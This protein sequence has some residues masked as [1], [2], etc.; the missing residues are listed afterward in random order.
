[1]LRIRLAVFALAVLLFAG[2]GVL[3]ERA[4]QLEEDAEYDR[5][6]RLAER[7]F[8]EIDDRLNA[9]LSE[10]EARSF[11]Q[12]RYLYVPEGAVAAD[13][14]WIRS[15][16][17]REPEADWILG[18][19]Q[20]DADGQFRSPLRPEVDER[21]ILT[22]RWYATEGIEG[23]E[24]ALRRATRGLEKLPDFPEPRP[25]Q[26]AA[27]EPVEEAPRTRNVPRSEARKNAPEPRRERTVQDTED[28]GREPLRE[29]DD[30]SASL[31]I[32]VEE[33]SRPVFLAQAPEQ[34]PEQKQVQTKTAPKSKK[35]RGEDR[36]GA[37]SSLNK[38]AGRRSG[39][40][41]RQSKTSAVNVY[42]LQQT[43]L[44]D[45]LEPQ[46]LKDARRELADANVEG[47]DDALAELA[48]E[49]AQRE[50]TWAAGAGGKAD[51]VGSPVGAAADAPTGAQA[52]LES[53]AA[54]G[55]S[56]EQA[57]ADLWDDGDERRARV[58]A[59]LAAI[60]EEVLEAEAEDD[61]LHDDPEWTEWVESERQ[62]VVA[63]AQEGERPSAMERKLEE[64]REKRKKWAAAKAKEEGLVPVAAPA[65]TRAEMPPAPA[66][67]GSRVETVAVEGLERSELPAGRIQARATVDELAALP[68]VAAPDV[69]TKAVVPAE[70][71]ADVQAGP[72]EL[73]PPPKPALDAGWGDLTVTISQLR[74]MPVDGEHLVLYRRVSAGAQTF[75][76][77]VVLKLPELARHLEK[78]VVAGTELAGYVSFLWGDGTAR[79]AYAFDHVFAA[80]FEALE[81]TALFDPV[82]REDADPL[83]FLLGVTLLLIVVTSAGLYLLYRMVAV[84]VR[85]AEQRNNFVSAVSHELKTPLTAIRMY[86][87]M[88]RDDIV[89]NE[90]KR[91]EYYGTITAESE[92]LSR[93]I[94]NV[95]ELAKLEKG[96]RT[97]SMSVGLLQPVLEEAVL[98]LGP[99]ARSRGF[100][101][102]L[103][104]DDDLP[105]VSFEHDAL[106]QV[107][108]NLVD[109]ALKFSAGSE[110]KRVILEASRDPAGGVCIRIRDR[111]PGV[112]A[113]Q[114]QRIFQ[115]FFR[116]E[117]E[118]TRSTKGT[119][120][121]LA[122]VQGLIE[123]M[124]GRVTAR[125]HPSGGFEV[126]IGLVPA[127]V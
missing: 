118:L 14:A 63:S 124:G 52:R 32:T 109:N 39:R 31:P 97:V 84:V 47:D 11:H 113:A 36:K 4:L 69:A 111:G 23:I 17:S 119:G 93:L 70:A 2:I 45:E 81:A 40:A 71:P 49:L 8:D 78:E 72:A 30:G 66:F 75:F 1:M 15:E 12:Y 35:R 54:S 82:P 18:W 114:L 94:N 26:V 117:R 107:L 96:T 99:H 62:A 28:D 102:E 43:E 38:A 57:I 37:S 61:E 95:L 22:T 104:A 120:I 50:A 74:G 110:D 68:G 106:L 46:A 85:F 55:E 67:G 88:L 42:G 60:D 127:P 77:G 112:P 91:Y 21:A 25:P 24:N 56:A 64:A 98:V 105:P 123:C 108:I 20:Y 51:V 87:E 3:V 16:L 126:E 100:T 53:G 76:Q 116:G 6:Q 122:L 34:E 5:H 80:P 115:P 58:D 86:S 59:D 65:P 13:R 7:V 83:P 9:L 101:L 73:Q 103:E 33:P 19:F 10:E 29:V 44:V 92:R 79:G 41:P 125:N 89:P 90:D 27:T 48:V 121:G